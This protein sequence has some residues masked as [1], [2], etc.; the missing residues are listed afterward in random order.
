MQAVVNGAVDGSD[1][2]KVTRGGDKTV[3]E[4]GREMGG[5]NCRNGLIL[6]SWRLERR[7]LFFDRSCLRTE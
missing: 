7:L 1:S 5:R 2:T 6:Q 3:R 4:K